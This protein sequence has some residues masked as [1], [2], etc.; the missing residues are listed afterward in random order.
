MMTRGAAS[1]R[2]KTEAVPI[3]TLRH[4]LAAISPIA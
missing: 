3:E 2:A 1:C 4:L